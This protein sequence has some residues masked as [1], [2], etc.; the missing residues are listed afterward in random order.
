MKITWN[1]LRISIAGARLSHLVQKDK[2][3]DH[4]SMTEQVK[5]VFY[6]V[7]KAKNKRDAE[8]VRKYASAKAFEQMEQLIM[9]GHDIRNN[10]KNSVLTEVSIIKVSTRKNE[11]PDRFVALIKGKRKSD[12]NPG[13]DNFSERWFFVRQGDWWLLDGMNHAH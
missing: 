12:K 13:I 7:E 5:S 11:K 4:G 6:R 3:W 2:I 9:R 8:T 10:F 1:S